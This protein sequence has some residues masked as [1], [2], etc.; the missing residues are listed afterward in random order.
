MSYHTHDSQTTLI[1]QL[2]EREMTSLDESEDGKISLNDIPR[3]L[4]S[5]QQTSR[6]DVQS[7]P[8]NNGYG[9]NM[10]NAKVELMDVALKGCV[11][12]VLRVLNSTSETTLV[13]TRCEFA[14]SRF[15]AGV[16]GNLASATFN[17]CV[18]H[19]NTTYGLLGSQSATIHLHGEATAINSNGEYG[20]F[21]HTSAKVVI[22][23]PSHHNTVYNNGARNNRSEEKVF[24]T[25][26]TVQTTTTTTAIQHVVHLT[27]MM[28]KLDR[29]KKDQRSTLVPNAPN[30]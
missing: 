12:A 20:I 30:I 7:N 4:M 22:H 16:F 18:F 14:N 8:G 3:L 26:L 28:L 21:A 23:L 5:M 29:P 17:N 15:G 2:L 19:D 24:S 25:C 10:S 6:D 9:I 1:F 11:H 27:S 13:A